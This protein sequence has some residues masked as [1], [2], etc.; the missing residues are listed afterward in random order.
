MWAGVLAAGERSGAM[1]GP[2]LVALGLVV[3]VAAV[4]WGSFARDR[5]RRLMVAAGLEPRTAPPG[6]RERVL[7]ATGIPSWSGSAHRDAAGVGRRVAAVAAAF[8]L[9]GA[10]WTVLRSALRPRLGWVEGRSVAF[11]GTTASDL[12]PSDWGWG[13]EVHLEEVRSGGRRSEVDLRVWAGGSGE[14]PSIVAGQPVTGTAVLTSLDPATSGFDAYLAGRGAVARASVSELVA[15][16]PP[17][18]PWL[19]AAAAARRAL[20]RGARTSLPDLEAELLLGLTIG[21]TS[22]MDPEVEEDFRASGLA[23]LVAVSGATVTGGDLVLLPDHPPA[24]A[25]RTTYARP[26]RAAAWPLR[27]KRA[28]LPGKSP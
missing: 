21:D 18:S 20:R 11:S 15:R 25:A 6:P 24:K 27:R 1:V 8:A 10:G 28:S 17:E 4:R 23:H 9:V 26:T 7:R 22:A 14:P 13:V 3:L 12:R 5:S 16:G 19:R 2:A